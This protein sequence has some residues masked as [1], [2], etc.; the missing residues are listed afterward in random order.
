MDNPTAQV[1]PDG[2]KN[3]NRRSQ[4][5]QGGETR[6]SPG[7]M[8][9]AAREKNNRTT[10]NRKSRSLSKFLLDSDIKPVIFIGKCVQQFGWGAVIGFC[11]G[12]AG[13]YGYAFAVKS[14][15]LVT[16]A[17]EQSK[18]APTATQTPT[19][20]QKRRLHGVIKSNDRPVEEDIEIGVLAT[21]Q[22]PFQSGVFSI[23]V[24]ESDR[25]QITLWNQ[26]YQRF[27][28]VELRPDVDGNVHDVIF[29]SGVL[30]FQASNKRNPP[31]NVRD[32][33][34]ES[35]SSQLSTRL[36]RPAVSQPRSSVAT[37]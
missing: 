28:L 26:G 18:D 23:E 33:Q 1:L 8:S 30:A 10:N 4:P 14:L 11:L 19:V 9:R 6:Q 29:P 36:T 22:G 3:H 37:R 25:Y 35:T 7:R 32:A 31:S 21:R 27:R 2:D 16:F 15:P 12:A 24:P 13:V 34:V 17:K 20:A 5:N